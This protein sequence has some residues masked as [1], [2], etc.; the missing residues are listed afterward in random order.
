MRTL[1]DEYRFPG[2]RPRARIKGVFGD[3]SARVVT[4]VRTQKKAVAANAGLSTGATTTSG[5]GA[6]GTAPAGTPACIWRWRSAGC[7]AGRARR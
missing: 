4:L 2:Y 5:C 6:S 3:P 7:S 1:L